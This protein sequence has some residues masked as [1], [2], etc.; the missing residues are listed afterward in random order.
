MS[1]FDNCGKC[2]A[3]VESGIL[4][5]KRI[6][7]NLSASNGKT[8]YKLGDFST[9]NTEGVVYM[10]EC[11]C[12]KR[13]IGRTC[14]KVKTRIR[15][16]WQNIRLGVM[17]HNLSNHYKEKHNHDPEGSIFWVL[18][19]IR[20]WWRGENID[21]KLSRKEGE[22]IYKLGTLT[23]YGHNVDFELKCFLRDN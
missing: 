2:K 22:W 16:H 7:K 6:K 13:Y 3:C 14:R 23:P 18:V 21:T 8:I 17:T 5:R 4:K 11:P 10:I 12:G 15:E 19:V 1:G 9:C 20:P